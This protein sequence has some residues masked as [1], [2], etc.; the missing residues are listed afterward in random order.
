MIIAAAAVPACERLRRLSRSCA[1]ASPSAKI[2]GFDGAY[3]RFTGKVT[4]EKFEKDA[5]V[6]MFNDH[7]IWELMYF[8]KARSPAP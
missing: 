8:G 6:E 4:I 7:A 1:N 5:R 3:H 2:V